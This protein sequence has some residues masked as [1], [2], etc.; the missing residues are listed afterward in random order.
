MLGFVLLTAALPFLRNW[1]RN[2][3]RGAA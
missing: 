2:R 1:R 3:K